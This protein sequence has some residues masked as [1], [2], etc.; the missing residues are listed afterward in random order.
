MPDLFRGIAGEYLAADAMHA[1]YERRFAAPDGLDSWKLE[2]RQH[3]RD[4]QFA[5]WVAFDRGEWEQALR[6]MEQER[7]SLAD[8]ERETVARGMDLYRVRVVEEPIAPYLQWELHLLALRAEYGEKI[9][10]IGP[11]V[12]V[13]LESAGALPELLTVGMETVYEFRY[14][15]T[16][17]LSGAHRYTDHEIYARC[18]DFMKALYTVGEDLRSFLARRVAAVDPQGRV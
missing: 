11:E 12:V 4:P 8:L 3:F 13:P 16:G 7:T 17:T 10:V 18:T 6:L 2:R 15:E 14:D 5:S 1:D 9:R